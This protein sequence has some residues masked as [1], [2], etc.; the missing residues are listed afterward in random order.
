MLDAIMNGETITYTDVENQTGRHHYTEVPYDIGDLSML[1]AENNMPLISVIVVNGQAGI[2]GNRFYDLWR[3]FYNDDCQDETRI[4]KQEFARVLEFQE[5]YRLA[6]YLGIES[7]FTPQYR[8]LR[9]VKAADIGRINEF[10]DLPEILVDIY[11]GHKVT[12]ERTK[13]HQLL[14]LGFAELLEHAGYKFF[15]NPMDCYAYR[16]ER[17]SLLIEAKTLDGTSSDEMR[18]VRTA[19]S[20]VLYYENFNLGQAVLKENMSRLILFEREISLPH[21]VFLEKHGCNSI[22]KNNTNGFTGTAKAVQLMKNNG[23][24]LT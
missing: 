7:H 1:C 13:R 15:E 17:V 19:L 23:I 4:F 20:Q 24:L 10:Q 22:W 11:A 3:K 16:Y 5:W 8:K 2:P 6:D 18:Q 14:L 9:S 12:V 21:Q